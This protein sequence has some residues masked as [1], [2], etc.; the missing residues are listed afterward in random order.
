MFR[1]NILL[2]LNHNVLTLIEDCSINSVNALSEFD[3]GSRGAVLRIVAELFLQTLLKVS[4]LVVRRD[5]TN[6][7]TKHSLPHGLPRLL[8]TLQ[9]R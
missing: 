4:T 7:P 6:A 1:S 2:A 3:Y 5:V 8:K 9:T